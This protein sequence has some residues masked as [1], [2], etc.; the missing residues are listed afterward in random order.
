MIQEGVGIIVTWGQHFKIKATYSLRK[1]SFG[2]NMGGGSNKNVHLKIELLMILFSVYL[3]LSLQDERQE[4]MRQQ[5]FQNVS[6]NIL[7]FSS[8]G[9]DALLLL[10]TDVP[11]NSS[12]KQGQEPAEQLAPWGGFV[13]VRW[14]LSTEM[15]WRKQPVLTLP[16][17]WQLKIRAVW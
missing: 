6:K 4:L 14:T 10:S 16:D 7:A 13:L 9:R 5:W 2:D 1:I 8:P 3:E 17:C 12:L 15:C 11:F